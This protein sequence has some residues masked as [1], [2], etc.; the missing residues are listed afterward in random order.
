MKPSALVVWGAGAGMLL[1]L[2]VL[3]AL[4]LPDAAE[5]ARDGRRRAV[6]T[7]CAKLGPTPGNAALG[8][9]PVAA[10][11]FTLPMHDGTPVKLSSLRG[12]VVLVNFW[13]TWCPTC[14][15]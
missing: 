6:Q 13:A 15:V 5:R 9:L 8:K 1:L 10:P 3:F 12:E 14:V 11:D 2:A 7:A 4:A